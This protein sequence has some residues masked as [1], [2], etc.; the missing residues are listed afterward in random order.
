[1]SPEE[2]ATAL[3]RVTQVP[4][5]RGAMVV[6]GD[7]GLVVAEAA[8][9]GVRS[10]AVAALAASLARRLAQVTETACLG[11]P[12]FVHLSAEEGALLA[13]PA[14]SGLVVVA[15]ASGEVNVGLARLEMLRAAEMTA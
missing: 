14:E 15:V 2:L 4:H 7:D 12:T 11:G 5:V 1:M 3:D 8:M 9:E 13:V 6:S 10:N